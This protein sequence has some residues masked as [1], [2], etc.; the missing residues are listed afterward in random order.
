[1]GSHFSFKNKSKNNKNLFSCSFREAN[2]IPFGVKHPDPSFSFLAPD[3]QH[4]E[5]GQSSCRQSAYFNSPAF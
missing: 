4:I 2:G 1:M 5:E 3:S